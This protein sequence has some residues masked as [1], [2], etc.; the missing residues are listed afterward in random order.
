[1]LILV[2]NGRKEK[3]NHSHYIIFAFYYYAVFLLFDKKPLPWSRNDSILGYFY[4]L[5]WGRGEVSTIWDFA[6]VDESE[7][8]G[9]TY[10]NDY[11][12]IGDET[13]SSHQGISPPPDWEKEKRQENLEMDENSKCDKKLIIPEKD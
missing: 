1:M 7:I 10:P 13:F 12:I 5:W 4:Q 3:P 9:N 6:E 11:G 8:F 2:I